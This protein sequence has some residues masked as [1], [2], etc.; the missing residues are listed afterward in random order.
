MIGASETGMRE[1]GMM[2]EEW[3]DAPDHAIAPI[4]KLPIFLDLAER[5]AVLAG[6]S[7]G[8][9]WKAELIFAAGARTQ[10]YSPRPSEELRATAR[11]LAES[12]RFELIE[13]A[14]K[15]HDLEGAAIAVADL[16][17]LSA[18]GEF[19]AAADACGVLANTV[20]KGATCDFYFGAVVSRSPIM[21]GATTDGT[22]PI[23]GQ[24]VRRAIELA[25]PPWLAQWGAMARDLRPDIKRRLAP[26]A[27]R[28]A[29]WEA[30]AQ[31][32]FEAP[33]TTRSVDELLGAAAEISAMPRRGLGRRHDLAAPLDVDLLTL[34]D[35]KFLQAADVI[36]EDADVLEGVRAFYRREAT[37]LRVCEGPQAGEIARADVETRIE[38]ERRD[39][40]S[41][42]RVTHVAA[43]RNGARGEAS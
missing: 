21:I 36:I 43:S 31:K 10:V 27:Q 39:G 5:K 30:F 6:D 33:P 34:A 24:W 29:F 7:A 28:R 37:R 9:A 8:L 38:A 18:A 25:L 41:V 22:A 11:R 40:R 26:G 17:T 20:D 1:D 42:A 19:K 13:R 2:L 32:A 3:I 12:A 35:V 15:P 14:W 4:S 16:E 23:L